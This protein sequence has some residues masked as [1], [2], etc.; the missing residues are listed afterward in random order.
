MLTVTVSPASDLMT[1]LLTMFLREP[2]EYNASMS[3]AMSF[4][5]NVHMCVSIGLILSHSIIDDAV[6]SS[7]VLTQFMN[8]R[9][10]LGLLFMTIPYDPFWQSINYTHGIT[11]PWKPVAVNQSHRVTTIG[12]YQ[13]F[14]LMHD[15]T[16]VQIF[17]T[18]QLDPDPGQSD[19]G[20]LDLCIAVTISDPIARQRDESF[21]LCGYHDIDLPKYDESTTLSAEG[22]YQLDAMVNTV[23][24]GELDLGQLD[25]TVN[26]VTVGES[27]PGHAAMPVEL[28]V[29]PL[30]LGSPING[31]YGLSNG[32]WNDTSYYGM[33]DLNDM[34]QA[35]QYGFDREL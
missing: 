21:P 27:D 11:D 9:M 10:S 29:E 22:L 23:S 2:D 34:S 4:S 20:H 12:E 26:T 1:Y 19:L 33:S 35:T 15:P 31:P 28:L 3:V 25:A 30:P 32:A 18:G 7:D 24:L 8:I 14:G 17:S 5:H 6:N 16:L 13:L